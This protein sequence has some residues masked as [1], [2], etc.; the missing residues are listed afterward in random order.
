MRRSLS[1]WRG[2][3]LI[4][5]A[6]RRWPWHRRRD[7]PSASAPSSIRVTSIAT[8]AAVALTLMVGGSLRLV[9]QGDV[10]A[11]ND[12]DLDEGMKEFIVHA[13]EA[14][15]VTRLGQLLERGDFRINQTFDGDGTV[16]LIAAKHGRTE[17]VR[18]LLDRGADPNVPS[19]G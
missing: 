1:R 14:G 11:Y 7:C 16:L 10:A 17:T 6:S 4:A 5:C 13:A 15:N 8:I 9:A 12:V 2:R 19:P 3:S 18:F